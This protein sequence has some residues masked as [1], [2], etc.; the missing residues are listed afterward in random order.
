MYPASKT[1][2]RTSRLKMPQTL[3][4]RKCSTCH[5]LVFIANYASLSFR[6]VGLPVPDSF[7]RPVEKFYMPFLDCKCHEFAHL[8]SGSRHT[9]AN[10]EDFTRYYRGSRNRPIYLWLH[11]C[12][13]GGDPGG[14]CEFHD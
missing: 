7:G 6:T 5:I 12:N 14:K 1:A 4:F 11:R 9:R 13:W 2:F 10:P 8:L 3:L